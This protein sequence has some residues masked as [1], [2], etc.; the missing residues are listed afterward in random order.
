LCLHDVV[1]SRII[2]ATAAV[3]LDSPL[4]SLLTTARTRSPFAPHALGYLK[5]G[6]DLTLSS[7]G[8]CFRAPVQQALRSLRARRTTPG[9]GEKG[10]SRVRD[11][12]EVVDSP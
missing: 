2:V 11:F 10:Q 12:G 6:L 1:G 5:A 4:A 9:G 8:G 7:T 3:R